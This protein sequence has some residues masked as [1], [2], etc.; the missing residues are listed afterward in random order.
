MLTRSK[1]IGFFDLIRCFC[2]QIRSLSQTLFGNPKGPVELGN[3][4]TCAETKLCLILIY[5]DSR[6]SP[7]MSL[8]FLYSW[9][10]RKL[11]LVR[12]RLLVEDLPL[13]KTNCKKLPTHVFALFPLSF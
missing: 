3:P 10:K 9:F 13:P 6:S 2:N 1:F 7:A 11:G 12:R 5:S 8:K 4:N